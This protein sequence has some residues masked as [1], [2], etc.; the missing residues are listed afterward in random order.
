M[1]LYT[2]R[3]H[4]RADHWDNSLTRSSHRMSHHSTAIFFPIFNCVC[5]NSGTFSLSMSN[6]RLSLLWSCDMVCAFFTEKCVARVWMMSLRGA[7]HL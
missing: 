6:M 7:S 1:V 3:T 5:R 2:V 4:T